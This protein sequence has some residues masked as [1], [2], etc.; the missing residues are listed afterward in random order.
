MAKGDD[1][2]ER[3]I[4][5]AVR[6]IRVCESL[7]DSTAIL[8]K[9]ID[10]VE[11]VAAAGHSV[12]RELLVMCHGGPFGEPDVVGDALTRMPGVAGFFGATT[13]ERAPIERAVAEQVRQ[14]KGLRLA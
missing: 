8:Q 3:L 14:F 5:F 9:A 10:Q 1:L 11:R 6:V 13:T 12:N 2:E 4:E 7:P